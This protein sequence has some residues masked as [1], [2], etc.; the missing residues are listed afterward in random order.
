MKRLA[1][2]L[3]IALATLAIAAVPANGPLGLDWHPGGH[4]Y[5]LLKNGSVSI[6]DGVTKAKRATIPPLFG[7][8]PVEIFSS[9]MTDGDFVFVSGFWGRTGSIWQYTSDGKP[10]ARYETPEQAASFD[11]GPV[12]R[13]IYLVSPVTNVVYSIDLGQHD[14]RGSVAKRVAYI[15]EAEAIGPVIFDRGRNRVMLG[16]TGRG[17][18]YEVDVTNGKYAPIAT[19]LGRPISLGIDA[20]FQT[21]FVA[22]SLSGRIHLFRLANGAFHAAGA[23]PTGLRTLSAVTL[24]PDDSLFVADGYNVYQLSMKTKKLT[25]I[26]Y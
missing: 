22:D 21:L 2:G 19:G 10:Y 11:I 14:Q 17:V 3:V 1:R 12:R 16:D 6:V 25:R 26:P 13:V 20:T 24:G 5:V 9:R 15:A 7:M 18:L 8:V 4:L 23:I